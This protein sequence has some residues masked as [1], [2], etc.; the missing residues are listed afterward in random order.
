MNKYTVESKAQDRVKQSDLVTFGGV[1]IKEIN[2]E[3]SFIKANADALYSEYTRPLKLKPIL[4]KCSH[5]FLYF[6]V[7]DMIENQAI[8]NQT[9]FDMIVKQ[10]AEQDSYD[11][12]D[13]QVY[14][15]IAGQKLQLLNKLR[16]DIDYNS[17]SQTQKDTISDTIC[18]YVAL[19]EAQFKYAQIDEYHRYGWSEFLKKDKYTLRELAQRISQESPVALDKTNQQYLVSI[20]MGQNN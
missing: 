19:S 4:S 12:V 18:K 10:V 9:F 7:K 13:S 5:S 1:E 8:V 3:L 20:L 15:N 16:F 14:M 6:L 2:R 11:K 17:D